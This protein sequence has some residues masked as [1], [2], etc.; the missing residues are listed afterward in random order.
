MAALTIKV[1]DIVKY[2][3]PVGILEAHPEYASAINLDAQYGIVRDAFLDVVYV[4]FFY[5]NKSLGVEARKVADLDRIGPMYDII[6]KSLLPA[7]APVV[8]EKIVREK[9]A[10]EDA[11]VKKEKPA[12]AVKTL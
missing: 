10:K 12:K 6:K 3:D 11:A 9:P 7:P 8:I 1:L 2:K 4:E 5:G